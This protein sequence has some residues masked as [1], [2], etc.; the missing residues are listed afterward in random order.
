MEQENSAPCSLNR[1]QGHMNPAHTLI[2]CFLAILILS[3]CQASWH[4]GNAMDSYSIGIRFETWPR[5]GL[6]RLSFSWFSLIPPR[7]WRHRISFRPLTLP[8][9][10]FRNTLFT[11]NCRL[12]T[13]CIVW[14]SKP[15]LTGLIGGGDIRNKR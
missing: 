9:K 2:V 14:Y 13:L 1:K 6:S 10:T 4:R 8:S 12:S 3:H 5:H 7:N 11:K 15:S